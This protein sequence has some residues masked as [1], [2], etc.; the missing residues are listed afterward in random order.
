M[1]DITH[2]IELYYNDELYMMAMDMTIPISWIKG[3]ECRIA[4]S[5]HACQRLEK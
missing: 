4:N 3:P 2:S 1:K 5:S